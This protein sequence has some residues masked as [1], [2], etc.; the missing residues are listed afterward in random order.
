MIIEKSRAPSAGGPAHSCFLVGGPAHSRVSLGGPSHSCVSVRGHANF[1]F[2]IG[3]FIE[4]VSQFSIKGDK[5]QKLRFAFSIYDMD[6]D[7]YISNGDLFQV[8]KMMV[9]NNLKDTQLQQIVDKT[10]DGDGRI[11][12]EEF[13]AVV[14][15]L[16]SHKKMVV[17]V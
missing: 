15:G 12:L 6:K 11:S 1:C 10:I 5:E 7:G 14:G 2:L 8:L 4:G 9:G 3:E 17:D 16:D 13:C